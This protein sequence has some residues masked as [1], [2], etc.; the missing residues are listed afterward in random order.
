MEQISLCTQREQARRAVRS[1]STHWAAHQPVWEEGGGR[2]E[3][4]GR[5]LTAAGPLCRRP[6]A[7]QRACCSSPS[8]SSAR[9]TPALRLSFTHTKAP[10]SVA[11]ENHKN[12]SFTG[13]IS[14]S[15][16]V[17][18]LDRPDPPSPCRWLTCR[19][20]MLQ[21]FIWI[22]STQLNRFGT[23][24]ERSNADSLLLCIFLPYF[25][26]CCCPHLCIYI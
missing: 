12:T 14:Q 13:G 24:V 5:P 10:Q 1:Q 2:D 19:N 22:Y 3:A 4:R 8:A 9:C 11:N 15:R 18:P 17:R 26:Y 16:G 20:T 7:R 25:C 21:G 23:T 6:W